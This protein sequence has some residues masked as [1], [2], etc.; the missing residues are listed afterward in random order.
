MTNLRGPVVI[1][2][3]IL[4]DDSA[5]VLAAIELAAGEAV[6]RRVELRLVYGHASLPRWPQTCRV[7]ERVIAGIEAAH[8]SLAVTT[9][10]HPGTAANALITAS[11]TAGLVV[12]ATQD[13]DLIASLT[14]ISRTPVVVVVTPA[15]DRVLV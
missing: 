2:M 11:N 3:D 9:A 12:L 14:S 10:I 13:A 4:D 8:P 5:L 7:L 1:G 15:P 6:R